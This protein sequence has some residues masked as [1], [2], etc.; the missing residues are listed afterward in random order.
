MT[1]SQAR[2]LPSLGPS[3]A[4]QTTPEISNKYEIMILMILTRA[5]QTRL[6]ITIL[7]HPPDLDEDFRYIY[8]L[9][10]FLAKRWMLTRFYKIFAVEKNVRHSLNFERK[11]HFTIQCS[12]QD[13][14]KC[15]S[16]LCGCTSQNW[17]QKNLILFWHFNFISSQLST[18]SQSMNRHWVLGAGVMYE[19]HHSHVHTL[20]KCTVEWDEAL[21]SAP[22]PVS[23]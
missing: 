15:N 4:T 13:S 5:P 9:D 12:N 6:N 16:C 17:Q 21:L 23:D 10:L 3:W 19:W 18:N 14:F 22:P 7:L 1:W 11:N 2:P 8:S 20:V